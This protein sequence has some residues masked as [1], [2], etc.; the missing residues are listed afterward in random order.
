M[1]RDKGSEQFKAL[2]VKICHLCDTVKHKWYI[3]YEKRI[4]CKFMQSMSFTCKFLKINASL[5]FPIFKTFCWNSL[6]CCSNLFSDYLVI[7]SMDINENF[8]IFAF[9]SATRVHQ[10]LKLERTILVL[11]ICKSTKCYCSSSHVQ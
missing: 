8:I 4:L 2:K 1:R 10:K 3:R 7:T 5:V 9:P 6:T 11:I